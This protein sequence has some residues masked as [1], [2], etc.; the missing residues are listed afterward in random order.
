M[1]NEVKDIDMK[2]RTYYFFNDIINI[3][4]FDPN[5]KIDEKSDKNI[6]IYCIRYVMI[7]DSK[8]VKI[9]SVNPLYLIFRNVSGYFEE[10][11]KSKYLTLVPTNESKEK[12]KKYEELWSNIKDLIRSITK[13][14]DDYDEKYMKIKFNSDDVIALNKTIEFLP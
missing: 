10:I 9:N 6:L 12:I 5:I 13:N 3:E 2:N 1:S 14:S 4:N 11:N 7:K 8:Y